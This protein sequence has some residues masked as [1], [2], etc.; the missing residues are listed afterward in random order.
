MFAETTYSPGG[1]GAPFQAIVSFIDWPAPRLM[2]W[3]AMLVLVVFF[4]VMKRKKLSGKVPRSATV[5]FIVTIL[6]SLR[7]VGETVRLVTATLWKGWGAV[8]A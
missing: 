1:T 8:V 6:P 2:Y 3:T 5:T 4:A 7:S